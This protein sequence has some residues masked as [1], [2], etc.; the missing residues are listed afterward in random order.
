[1]LYK[2]PRQSEFGK[3]VAK[4]KIYEH[5][6][7]STAL[8]DKFV[9][10]I[11]KIVWTHKLA[12]ETMNLESSESVPEIQVFDIKLKVKDLSE[13]LLKAIDKVIPFPIIFQLYY[14]D[15]IKIKAAYKRP[16]DADKNKWVVESYFETEWLDVDSPKESLPVALN[17][18]K[19]YEQMLQ[20]LIPKISEN[21]THVSI[22]EQVS[23]IQV[24]RAK[25]KEYEK[26]KAQRDKEKQFN[27]KSELNKQ[28]KILQIELDKLK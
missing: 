22:K 27:R 21:E 24:Y 13:E 20:V 11:D 12:S 2:Y 8:K 7:A 9:K 1:M 5:A 15:K 17:L 28:L 16:S 23:N 19:L 14:E 26:L 6:N 3:I 10:Q 4:N 25:E 18:T